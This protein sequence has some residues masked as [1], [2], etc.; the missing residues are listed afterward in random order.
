[1]IPH[2]S[3]TPGSNEPL[4][5]GHPRPAVYG[6]TSRGDQ[7][8]SRISPNF[9]RSSSKLKIPHA[10]LQYLLG[11]TDAGLILVASVLG[12]GGYQ[13]YAN[14]N[15]ADVEQFLG[16]GVIAALLYVLIGQSG[17]FYDLRAISSVRRGAVRVVSKRI[18]AQW[19]LVGLLLSLLAFLMK[20]GPGLLKRIGDL[21][22]NVGARASVG[23]SSRIE[24]P[25][26]VG[27]R[28]RSSSGP[29]RDFDRHARRTRGPQ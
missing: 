18:V 15:F 7:S 21:L 4:I 19:A 14:G 25:D 2:R 5:A 9:S 11:F 20:I 17:G 1:V 8:R 13:L 3:G 27:G 6:T 10:A 23:V 29:A 22:C 16:A 28:G 26:R 12:S 24:A